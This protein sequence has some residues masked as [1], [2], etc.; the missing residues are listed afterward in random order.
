MAQAALAREELFAL[1]REIARIEGRLAERLELPV[2][3]PGAPDGNKAAPQEGGMVVRRGGIAGPALLPVGVPA[4]DDPLG[5]GLPLAAMTEIHGTQMRDA[6]AVAGF[7]LGLAALALKGS[8]GDDR[9][10]LWVSATGMFAEAG[11]PY[12]PGILSRYGIPAG[13]MLFCRAQRI[14]Q[15]LWA[16]EEAAALPALALVLLEIGGSPKKL[17]LTATRRL[18]R[19]A[20][21][22]GRPLLLLRQAA[23]AEPT[24][25]PVRLHVSAAPAGE[26]PLLR[27]TPLSGV[28]EGSIG[29]PA[30]AVT[31]TRC[32]TNMPASATLEWSD[33]AR[34]F[35]AREPAACS[36]G[37]I[38]R[39]PY[40]GAVA[41]PAQDRPYPAA[42]MGAGLAQHREGKRAA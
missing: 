41:A 16:A 10:I 30:V 31:I 38:A 20:Q 18:H 22:A 17:D 34:A 35:R 26:R 13:R 15:A 19:R 3:E 14:E 4:L 8:P 12:M 21:L 2:F 39:A 28:L 6:G 1:R 24:A 32:R 23:V 5:G 42:A 36:S 33:D 9:P 11:E 29:P 40:H 7:A 37:D 25:A 27:G